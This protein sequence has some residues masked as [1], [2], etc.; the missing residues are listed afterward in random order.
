M[1]TLIIGRGSAAKRHI[2]V[3]TE[4]GHSFTDDPKE[5]DYAIIASITPNHINDLRSLSDAEFNGIC[6]VEK[7]LFMTEAEKFK[8]EFPVY[9]GYQLRFHPLI[10]ALRKSLDGVRIHSVGVHSGQGLTLWNGSYC[11]IKT[12]GGTL[13]K[14]YSHELDLLNWFCG[15]CN[16]EGW[17]SDE[18]DC[19]SISGHAGDII[20]SMQLNYINIPP[21]RQFIVTTDIG[22]F[23]VDLE[24][25]TLNDIPYPESPDES[26]RKMH[27]AI[28]AGGKNVCTYD[29]GIE[30]IKLIDELE[31]CA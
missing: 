29:E 6:L 25:E 19:I 3:L 4:L 5:A 10:V 1:K 20:I 7:P 12:N 18:E 14:E 9:V 24:K 17:I 16:L 28:F 23:I 2:R 8:P 15:E 11:G 13:P 30:V 31:P 22:T 21:I 27:K 26:T